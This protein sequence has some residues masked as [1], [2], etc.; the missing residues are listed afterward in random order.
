MSP[1]FIKKYKKDKNIENL[2]EVSG[3]L[4]LVASSVLLG[5]LEFL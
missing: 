4:L 2:L 3:V 5:V 1:K